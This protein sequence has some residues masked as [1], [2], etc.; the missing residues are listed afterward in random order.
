MLS[1]RCSWQKQAARQLRTCRVVSGAAA[2]H[3]PDGR[4]LPCH[5]GWVRISWNVQGCVE[6]GG[7]TTASQDKLGLLWPAICCCS[8]LSRE[9]NFLISTLANDSGD[10]HVWRAKQ[11]RS[12]STCPDHHEGRTP[13]Q[14]VLNQECA[15]IACQC[16]PS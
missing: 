13:D 8:R 9:C 6:A 15:Q 4:R 10:K 12:S 1:I 2:R 16:R 5:R 14:E 11:G 3:A 7:S